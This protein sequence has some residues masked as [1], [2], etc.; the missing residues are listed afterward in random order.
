MAKKSANHPALNVPPQDPRALAQGLW[1]PEAREPR[2]LPKGS[3]AL[4]FHSNSDL[5]G[6]SG[7]SPGTLNLP[8]FLLL[9]IPFF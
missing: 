5:K 7:V 8:N 2:A 6:F 1:E 4:T 3:Q 9:F